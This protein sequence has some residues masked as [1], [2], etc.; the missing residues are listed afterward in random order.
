MNP[1]AKHNSMDEISALSELSDITA[2]PIGDLSDVTNTTP[3]DKHVLVYDGITDNKYENRL[4]VEADI[5]DLG[6][7]LTDVILDTSPQLGGSLDVQTNT[8][9]TSTV[10]GNITLTPNGTG[11]I[12]LGNYTLDG[13]Q[14]VGAGQDNYVLTYDNGTGLI[15]HGRADAQAIKM[16][17]MRA[18]ELVQNKISDK[19]L[20]TLA[21]L[22]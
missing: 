4:L 14:T 7:Y 11:N 5:S 15:S 1:L 17:I 22:K 20:S 3:A 2:E 8:I 19:I 6:T 13:D 12:D 10:N 18:L 9:N 21:E 16:G